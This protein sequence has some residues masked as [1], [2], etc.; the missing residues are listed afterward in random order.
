M[1]KVV[2]ETDLG[3]VE[4]KTHYDK[5]AERFQKVWNLNTSLQ[6]DCGNDTVV[7]LKKKIDDQS[8][9]LSI[10][11]C[12]NDKDNHIFTFFNPRFQYDLGLL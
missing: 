4:G 7:I 3:T 12:C 2:N 5:V 9:Y 8:L 1:I 10:E 6:C 11:P